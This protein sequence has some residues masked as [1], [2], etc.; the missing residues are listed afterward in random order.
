[1]IGKISSPFSERA[2]AHGQHPT[3]LLGR[4]DRG[5]ITGEIGV[6][7]CRAYPLGSPAGTDPV[8]AFRVLFELRLRLTI[9][10]SLCEGFSR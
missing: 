8:A 5:Q 1:M 3:C 10:R 9:S 4:L 2:R 6:A 7:G